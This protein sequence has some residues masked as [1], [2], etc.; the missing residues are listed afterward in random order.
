MARLHEVIFLCVLV[1]LCG[2]SSSQSKRARQVK[3]SGFLSD[4]SKLQPT[5]EGEALLVYKNPGANWTAYDKI[6]LTPVAY[7]GGRDTYPE[8]VTRADLQELVN[9]F[10][11]IIHK[12]LAA[13]YQMVRQPSPGTLKLRVALTS[14]RESSATV[15]T[16]STVAPYIVNPLRNAAASIS[17]ESPFVGEASVEAEFTDAT[18]GEVLFAGVERR[19]GSRGMGTATERWRDVEEILWYWGE[20]ARYRLCKLRGDENCIR[21]VK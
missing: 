7:Y 14:V 13:D 3:E 17:G 20:T 10:Y 19:V 8:G 15:D 11:Y 21:P 12:N 1:L 16:I 9:R 6:L 2:C 4:Y 5:G 18:N